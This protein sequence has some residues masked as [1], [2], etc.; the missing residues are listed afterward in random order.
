[1]LLRSI[2]LPDGVLNGVGRRGVVGA[3]HI[4]LVMV[5]EGFKGVLKDLKVFL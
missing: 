5:F 2:P 1:M 4:H 3:G